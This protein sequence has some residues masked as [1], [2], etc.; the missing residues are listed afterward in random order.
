VGIEESLQN[1]GF[2]DGYDGDDMG[3]L[4]RPAGA[5]SSGQLPDDLI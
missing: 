1:T 5:E 2:D 4:I 3:H